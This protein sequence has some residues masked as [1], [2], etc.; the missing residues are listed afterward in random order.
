MTEN[1]WTAQI[2]RKLEG[3]GKYP[4]FEQK[5][6]TLRAKVLSRRETENEKAR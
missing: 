4:N 6:P 3:L 2:H 1:S 5:T